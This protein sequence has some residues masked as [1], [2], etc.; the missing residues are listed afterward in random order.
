MN[1]KIKVPTSLNDITI[2]QYQEIKSLLDDEDLQGIELDNQIL[3]I[4]LGFNNVEDISKKDRNILTKDV[5]TALLND[6]SFYQTFELNGVNFGMIPNFDNITN[7]EY[8]DLIKYSESED[9]LHKFMA[10]CYRPIVSKDVFKNYVIESYN[11]TSTYSEIMKELPMSIARGCKGFFLTL[12][13]DL[14][15]HSLMSMGGELT[16]GLVL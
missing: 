4:V 13:N 7:G 15:N 3:R 16:K 10:V 6:G 5:E 11:G 9:D 8:T 14:N 2:G 1:V 12:L